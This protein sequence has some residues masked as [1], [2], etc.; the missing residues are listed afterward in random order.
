MTLP[1]FRLSAMMPK[2][3]V[4]VLLYSQTGQL[5]DVVD[6]ILAPLEADPAIEVSVHALRPVK[7]F[8]YPWPFF[9]FMDA[10]PESALMRPCAMEPLDIAEDASF[11]LV[12]LPYQVW[13]LA[14]SLPMMSF[15]KSAQAA[16]LLKGKPV[17][18]VI[19]CRN[20]W[21]MAQEKMKGLLL[22]VGAKLTD[23]VALTDLSPTMATLITTPRWLWFGKKTGFWG[24]PPAGLTSAQVSGSRR[25]GRALRE[26]LHQDAEKT[27]APMLSGLEAVQANPH[28][29]VSERTGTHSFRI[30]G[31]WISSMG[32]PGS[33]R[34]KPLLATYTAFLILLIITVVPISLTLQALLRPFMR[35][36]FAQLKTEFEKPSG[37]S[38]E[39]MAMFSD[40]ADAATSASGTAARPVGVQPA[41]RQPAR[42]LT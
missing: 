15:L 34:R 25:F 28:L 20:M 30:W 18:T 2:K 16:R 22:Q 17:V 14:P 4:L 10:F 31:G 12:I 40:A 26:A 9:P 8:P 39:R 6:Q 11:D 27:G 41:S 37:C 38:G 19:A 42:P 35:K 32:A 23:N 3:R 36:R 1:L 21:L 7:P 5:S 24:L 33:P 13:Y 29:L